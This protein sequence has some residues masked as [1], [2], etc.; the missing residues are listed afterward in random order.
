MLSYLN[1][2]DFIIS[3]H[4]AVIVWFADR[5]PHPMRA[6]LPLPETIAIALESVKRTRI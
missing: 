4:E 6:A 2:L 5:H 3:D 1:R